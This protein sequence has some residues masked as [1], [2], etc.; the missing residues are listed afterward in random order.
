MLNAIKFFDCSAHKSNK[1]LLIPN[2]LSE[3]NIQAWFNVSDD[4]IPNM[5]C[6]TNLLPRMRLE[7]FSKASKQ[8]NPCWLRN[9][10]SSCCRTEDLHQKVHNLFA[11]TLNARFPFKT[12]F[13]EETIPVLVVHHQEERKLMVI[14]S[15]MCSI[16]LIMWSALAVQCL[17]AS[18]KGLAGKEKHHK[19]F[20]SSFGLHMNLCDRFVFIYWKLSSPL[21][22]LKPVLMLRKLRCT[23]WAKEKLKKSSAKQV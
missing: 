14:S 9:D 13:Q 5:D 23:A 21:V 15:I 10:P 4:S 22:V 8:Q 19:V 7:F 16:R 20:N 6:V 11:F 17:Y 18:S 12:V 3:A 2:V 1:Y